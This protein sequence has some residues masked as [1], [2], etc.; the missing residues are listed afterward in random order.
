[1]K[2]MMKL[3]KVAAVLML[4][5]T[6]C[7]QEPPDIPVEAPGNVF[8]ID[9]TDSPANY[10]R[11]DIQMTEIDIYHDARGW[12]PLYTSV[13]SMNILTLANGVSRNIAQH[14]NVMVGHYSKVR[15]L[16]ADRNTV[17]LNAPMVLGGIDYDAGST[18]PLKWMHSSY[19]VEIPIDKQVTPE[20]GAR[21]L[22]DFDVETSITE[23]MTALQIDPAI[24][25]MMHTT[26]G[27]KGVVFGGAA[28]AFIRI[29][30][31]LHEYSAYSDHEGKF[32][33]RG[34]AAGE[35]HLIIRVMKRDPVTGVLK[36]KSYEMD[37]VP[38]VNEKIRD[39]GT[40]RM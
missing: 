12:I 38:I 23:G 36:E 2:T 15:I 33:V 24:N 40:I 34:V 4:A 9:M 37:D 29:D 35:Y 19:Y 3:V 14:N 32:L 21:L 10:R 28:P 8:K 26:T 20:R 18:L 1:M 30:N 27:L 6:S 7:N 25:V 39:I 31:G 17:T 16:F 22:L 11:V 5:S 13:R